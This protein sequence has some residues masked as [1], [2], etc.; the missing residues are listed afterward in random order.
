MLLLLGFALVL[1]LVFVV[2]VVFHFSA[3]T[4]TVSC[5]PK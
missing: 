4:V 3:L 1:G 5:I 2:F